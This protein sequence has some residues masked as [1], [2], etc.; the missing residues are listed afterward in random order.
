MLFEFINLDPQEILELGTDDQN[1]NEQQIGELAKKK[2][3]RT[4]LLNSASAKLTQ[5]FRQWWKQGNY[6]F[7]LRA[8][9]KF[10]KIWVSDDIRPEKIALESRSTGLQ[11]F[12]SFYLIFLVETQNALK[13][14]ILLLDEAG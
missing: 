6:V 11:W 5:E 7:D 10:F 3:E 13:N 2:E 14:S 12:L 8:D 1:L 9:G 4:V